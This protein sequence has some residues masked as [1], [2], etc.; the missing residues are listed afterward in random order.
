M[1]TITRKLPNSNLARQK[2]LN[3]AENKSQSVTPPVQALS[4]AT[5]VRLTAMVTNYNTSLQNVAIAQAQ[6]TQNTLLKAPAIESTRMFTSHFIQVFNLGVARG[7]YSAAERSYFMLEVSSNALP[8]L[9]TET[10]VMQWASRIVN[11]DVPRL[12]AGGAPMVNPDAA[13]VDTALTAASNLFTTQS[14]LAQQLDTRQEAL[15]E[16]NTEADKLIKRVWDEV[17]TFYGEEEP[18]SMRSDAREW[19]VVYITKGPA[20]TL[21]GLVKNAAGN[22][23][24]G[25]TVELTESGATTT[26]NHEGRYTLTTAVVGEVT[27]LTTFPALPPVNTVIQIPEHDNALTIEVPD[28]TVG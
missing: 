2:A 4:A 21:T 25:A 3:F 12:A 13:E 23:V 1:A 10:D 27:L 11:G 7:K 26:T 9:D 22:G 24:E 6:L 28:I 19:G 16:L 18:D 8:A 14:N 17:E 20:A 5:I 15:E